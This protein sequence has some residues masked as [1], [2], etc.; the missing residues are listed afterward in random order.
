MNLNIASVHKP[1]Q[2]HSQK[3][4]VSQSQVRGFQYKTVDFFTF[5]LLISLFRSSQVSWVLFARILMGSKSLMTTH[6]N[7]YLSQLISC[8]HSETLFLLLT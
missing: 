4:C 8:G 1:L 3:A 2:Q 6:V 7:K 5:D